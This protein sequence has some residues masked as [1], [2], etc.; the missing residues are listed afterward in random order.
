MDLSPL[1]AAPAPIPVHATL[2]GLALLLGA[3]Q[4]AGP[5]GTGMHRALG[6]AWVAAMAGVAITS[7]WIHE[8]RLI[9]PFSPIH[10]LSALTLGSLAV[11][12]RRARRG[13][14]RAHRAMALELYA[15]ALIVTGAFTLLPGR[16]M[17]DVVF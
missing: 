10:A 14:V 12:V 9:G 2:A 16:V 3:V 1:W 13:Q 5:K 4:L 7:F 17:H 15:L 6:Y 11:L 8:F